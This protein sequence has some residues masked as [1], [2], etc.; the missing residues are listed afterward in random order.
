MGLNVVAIEVN[1]F[2][3]IIVIAI[4]NAVNR[5]FIGPSLNGFI[6][7]SGKVLTRFIFIIARNLHR[8]LVKR[9]TE[10][11]CFQRSRQRFGSVEIA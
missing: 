7:F 5:S 11:G 3:F 4:E 10:A 1:N 2:A 9:N 8:L 6:I